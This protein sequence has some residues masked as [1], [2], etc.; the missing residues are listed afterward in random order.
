MT[1]KQRAYLKGLANS[2][3]CIFQIGKQGLT[4]IL[5]TQLDQALEAR[6]LIKIHLLETIPEDV[7]VISNTI[8]EKTHSEIVQ[9]LGSKLTLFRKRKEKSKI[10]LP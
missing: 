3:P 6:E 1:S 9:I 2:I 7:Q 5:I 10:D 4:D 8:A